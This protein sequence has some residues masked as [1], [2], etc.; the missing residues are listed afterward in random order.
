[1]NRTTQMTALLLLAAGTMAFAGCGGKQS[2]PEKIALVDTSMPGY[3]VFKTNCAG[4]HGAELQG[5]S[6]PSL[7]HI[8]SR[9]SAD[10]LKARIVAGGK[11]MP[12]FN[13]KRL[14]P[15]QLTDLVAWLAKQ[16]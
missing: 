1:M 2:E 10:Q 11:G 4:C 14:E 9:L 7:A 6:G 15:A 5:V 3:Q 12:A 16:Q 8:G 13:E